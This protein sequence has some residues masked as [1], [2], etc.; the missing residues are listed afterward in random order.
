MR[1]LSLF[2]GF[3]G[4]ELAFGPL[5]WECAAVSEIDPAACAV[6]RHHWPQVPNLGDITAITEQQVVGLGS[7]DL[8]VFGSPCQD[9]SVAGKRAGLIGERS[10][11]FFDAMRV[12]RWARARFALWENVP[13]AFSSNDGADFAAV[14]GEMAG[15][16][17]DV[18][19]GGWRNTGFLLGAEGLVE[20]AVLDA[21]FFGVPQRRRRVFA[22]CDIGD[23]R[24][25]GPILL[26]RESLCGNSPPSREAGKG[27]THDL[28]PSLTNSGRGVERGGDSRGQ[29][30]VV[31]C[32]APGRYWD[33]SD[34]A[35]TLDASNAS[36][37]QAMPEKR[38]FQAVIETAPTIR[39]G[40]N[41]TGG[42]RPIGCDV[43]TCESLLGSNPVTAR[44]YGD[45]SDGDFDK[46][47]PTA[48]KAS[49]YTRGK[50]G[51]PADVA[52]PLSADADKGD[53][54]TLICF[55]ASGQ[56]GFTPSGIAPPVAATDGGG[57]NAPTIAFTCKDSGQDAAEIS[58]TLRSMNFDQSRANGGGQVAIATSGRARGDDGR[59][60]ARPE[61]IREELASTLDG[62]KVDA[63]A[64]IERGR[65]DG[66]NLEAQVDLAYALTNPG[67]G[68]RSPSRNLM[69]PQA[70]VRRLTPRECERL[71]ATPDNHTLVDYRGKPMADG[72]RYKMIGNGF[73]VCVVAWIGQRIAAILP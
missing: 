38:R 20:W 56:D 66:Q 68:G 11:L 40:G 31:A 65:S 5:G 35:D 16:R 70:Q 58:P 73:A 22:L 26:E 13:G 52:P 17:V 29:D 41:R 47:I 30:P 62:V 44:P 39:S 25:R 9:L 4:A 43:D 63:V 12:V 1:Y 55:R 3:G 36:K 19:D 60:Y 42:D 57:A 49:H 14:V 37:Q 33:G 15:V 64:F 2:S 71:Q 6:L 45:R 51:A 18:P 32:R 28:A 8:V 67:E 61:H 59:G 72:P 23:W 24:S 54:D 7:I 34:I 50:D 21:Q 10:G 48:F 46:L 69:T 27:T 53:Q